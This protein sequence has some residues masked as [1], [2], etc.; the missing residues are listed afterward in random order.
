M[1]KKWIFIV[2]IVGMLGW[3]IYDFGIKDK[4]SSS[5]EQVKQLDNNETDKEERSQNKSGEA[6]I[7]EGLEKG[8]L[9]PDFELET[10]EGEKVSLSD[11]RGKRVMLNFWATW[12]P[13]C[14]A[15]MPDM[16]KFHEN[17]DVVILAV[18]LTETESSEDNVPKFV[19]E[20]GI[21]F[22]V[23]LDV[24]SS[25]STLYQIRPIPTTYLID[26][27]GMIHNV[28]FGAINYELMVQEFEK[29]Q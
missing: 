28:A 27:N 26:S 14:R 4:A 3:A 24:D 10:L 21:T 7:K 6:M 5:S 19:E 23:P 2:I 29:M 11:F 13:P 18:N 22:R 16:Q 15:E 25:V 8:D 1:N 20:Y 9:A 17:K 12:C